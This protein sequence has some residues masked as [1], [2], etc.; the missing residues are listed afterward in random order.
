MSRRAAALAAAAAALGGCADR[1]V[2]SGPSEPPSTGTWAAVTVAAGAITIVLAALLVLPARRPGGST[3][4]SWVLALQAGGVALAGSTLVGAAIRNE[5]LVERSGDE[6]AASLVRLS[7]LDG[8]GDYF[9]LVV[10]VTSVLAAL[11]VAA[12]ALAARGAADHDPVE[13]TIVTGVLV[14][15][16][17]AS[18]VCVGLVVYGF[19]HTGLVLAA[20]AFPLL[21]AAAVAAWPSEAP[22]PEPTPAPRG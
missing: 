8:G 22:P 1:G 16:A 3:L 15:E 6:Q 18:L 17:I 19:R 11:L 13:R 9:S 2:V 12:L 7:G 20:L 5:Q 4:A 14:V 10:F 21:V